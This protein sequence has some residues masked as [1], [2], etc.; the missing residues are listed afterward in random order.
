[1]QAVLR[2]VY[3]P[4]CVGCDALVAEDGMLCG[5]CWAET[6]LIG[7]VACDKCGAPM[8]D[9]DGSAEDALW[10]DDCLAVE[11]PWHRGRAAM[12][13]AGRGRNMV[14]ALKHG[15]RQDIARPAASWMLAAAHPI[16]EPDMV[17]VPVP[18]HWIRLLQ[19]RYNQA[20]L[21]ANEIGKQAGLTVVAQAL[22]RS[23]RTQKQD[24][25]SHSQRFENTDAAITMRPASRDK[26]AGKSVLLVDDV[27]TSGATLT[28]ATFA[29]L[30]GGA[31]RVNVCTMA[32]VAKDT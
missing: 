2:V 19:R 30:A 23:R 6:P 14:L 25:L 15:D 9:G 10:C 4:R 16:L 3:P 32:R 24:G 28:A 8:L 31:A 12:V 17:V 20:A 1:M 26:I 13:Y 11:R 29:L 27:M 7:G 5:P 21:L 22:V 18:S